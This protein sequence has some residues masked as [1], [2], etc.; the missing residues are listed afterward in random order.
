MT[1]EEFETAWAARSGITVE[2]LR[3]LGLYAEQCS[4]GEDGCQGWAMG[5]PREDAL[6][7]DELRRNGVEVWW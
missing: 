6:V 4:C 1:R 5:H 7:E 3:R 2:N